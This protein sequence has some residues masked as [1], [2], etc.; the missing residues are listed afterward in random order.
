MKLFP[1]FQFHSVD[2]HYSYSKIN[3]T[4]TSK[5]NRTLFSDIAFNFV[6]DIILANLLLKLFMC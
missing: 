2:H 1:L 5:T 6:S 4:K 3:R